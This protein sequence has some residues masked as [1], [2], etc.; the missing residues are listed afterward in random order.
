M[1]AGTL[2]RDLDDGAP[3]NA[4]AKHPA[5][6][7]LPILFAVLAM[8]SLPADRAFAEGSVDVNRGPGANIRHALMTGA[9]IT[10][11]PRSVL[12]V[13]AQAGETIQMASSL[14]GIGGTVRLYAPGDNPPGATPILDCLADQPAAGRIGSRAAELAGP[15]PSADPDAYVPCTFVAPTSGTYSVVL[16]G[17]SLDFGNPGTVDAPTADAAQGHS[18]SMWDVTVR[19]AA[20]AKQPGRAYS[21][22]LDLRTTQ[23][24]GQA[25]DFRAFLYTKTGY[26]YRFDFYRQ[27]GLNWKLAPDDV[28]ILNAAT[29]ERLFA[30]F[31]CGDEADPSIGRP[32]VYFDAKFGPVD[33]RYPVF[34]APT[35]PVTVTGAGGLAATRNYASAPISPASNPLSASFTGTDGQPDATNRGAGGT[36]DFTSPPAMEGLGYELEIDTN[37]DGT[38]GNG[39]DVVT[40]GE[41]STTGTNAYV[42]NGLDAAGAPPACGA[43]PYRVRSTLSEVH[44]AM[45]DVENSDGTR[46]ER[47]SLPNDPSLGD[48][49]AASYDNRDPFKNGFVVTNG[50]PATVANGISGPGFNA[51]TADTGNTDYIDTWAQLPEVQA[52]GTLQIN[53]ADLVIGKSASPAVYQPGGELTFTLAVENRGPDTAVAPVVVDTLPADLTV[54]STDPACAVAG[55]TITCTLPTLAAGAS[56]NFAVTTRVATTA[57]A[58][59]PNAAAVDS[60]TYDSVPANNFTSICVPPAQ[61]D[62]SIVKTASPTPVVPGEDVIYTLVA[63]NAGPHAAVQTVVTDKLPSEL[64]FVSASDGCVNAGGTLT[65]TIASL[66]A[67]ASQEFTVTM[68]APSSLAD[69]PRNSATISSLT[70]DTDPSN[71][72]ATVCPPLE[73]KTD[74]SIRKTASAPQV[75]AGGQVMYTLSVENDGPSDATGVKVVDPIPA[76]LTIVSAQAGK[77]TCS[78]LGGVVSCNIGRLEAGATM[79]VLVTATAPAGAA[80]PVNTATVSGNEEDTDLRNNR[81]SA[82]VC[83]TIT[84]PPTFDL[85]VTKRADR[86][87]VTTGQPV[88]YRIAVTNRGPAAAPDTKLVDTFGARGRVLSVRTT[89]G[90]CRRGT[91]VQCELGT[92]ESG[93]RVEV[94]IRIRPTSTGTGKRNVVSTTASGT[95]RDPK[96]NLARETITVRKVALR[97]T[98]RVDRTVLRA[99]QTAT[100]TIRV[101]NPTRGI[102]HDVRVC[103]DL[104]SGLVYVS[105]SPRAK[106]SKG[107][108]CW[109]AVKRLSAGKS[110]T[111]RMTV[112]AVKGTSGRK[113]NTATASSPDSRTLRAKRTVRV[114]GGSV[115]P[116][117]VTG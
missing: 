74:L 108:Y 51:W 9:S 75:A 60:D 10:A 40:E 71:N 77:G 59:I 1:D 30:S 2:K 47:L 84:E 65:C 8:L 32:C 28:G 107:R 22:A 42:W 7:L 20:G 49:L 19:D 89:Q 62:V 43:V 23:L 101:S 81:A 25:G 97:L 111:Y 34:F 12:Q 113:V 83:T 24:Q 13:Y 69:C 115:R 102:A 16:S 96:N 4:E 17:S 116:G 53:C 45:E 15:Q 11:G 90:T 37:N 6:W 18:A 21:F 52:T 82:T 110:K 73:G 26:S 29:D 109:P 88:T 55:Q 78:T 105:S 80:C 99:G 68:K 114:V 50:T 93:G 91:P 46:I 112:R 117:G 70:A 104:P 92:V 38:F 103:D 61:S 35:D 33:R 94:T 86:R 98:K 87:T 67:G 85:V 106:L 72:S 79:Q 64:E 41:L 100:Y 76:G 56:R 57:T 5:R 54:V 3:P 14:I 95:D 63:S 39:T 66:A 27:A 31:A 44:F 36:I 48:P 58:C